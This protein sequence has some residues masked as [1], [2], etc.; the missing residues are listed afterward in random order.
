MKT[1][2]LSNMRAFGRVRGDL[3]SPLSSEAISEYLGSIRRYDKFEIQPFIIQTKQ[4]IED[5]WEINLGFEDKVLGSFQGLYEVTLLDPELSSTDIEDA[6]DGM[7]AVL[8]WIPQ[9]ETLITPIEKEFVPPSRILKL[10]DAIERYKSSLSNPPP[11]DFFDYSVLFNQ[12]VSWNQG[13]QSDYNLWELISTTIGD[14][15]VIYA[16]HFLRAA[17]EK[18]YFSG[19][20]EEAITKRELTPIRIKEAVDVENAIHNAYK[21]VEAVYGGTLPSS[22]TQVSNSLKQIG[23]NPDEL[24]GYTN[25]GQYQREPILEKI[26]E[27]RRARDERAAHGRIHQ[28][29]RN[30]FYQLMDSQELARLI[31][32]RFIIS[33]YPEVRP[34]ILQDSRKRFESSKG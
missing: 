3:K 19:E 11:P 30:T 31:L 6:L 28:N 14:E 34:E 2:L 27:L 5:F 13:G 26:K 12:H 22:W 17:L 18:F 4:T 20:L 33:R 32:E 1:F 29:R 21:V 23:I 16:S 10:E 8:H 25:R 15:Q 9:V 24:V 7:M